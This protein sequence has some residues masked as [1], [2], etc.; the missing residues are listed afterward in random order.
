VLST[1]S[2]RASDPVPLAADRSAHR[3]FE[4]VATGA[5][6]MLVLAVAWPVMA[7][8]GVYPWA[9]AV[10]ATLTLVF[11][12]LAVTAGGWR[13]DTRL[14]LATL[15]VLVAVGLQLIPL[16][17]DMLASISPATVAF[18]DSYNLGYALSGQ[19][20]K[21]PAHPLSID[22]A[23]TWRFVLFFLIA[24]ALFAGVRSLG[25]VRS[26]RFLVTT[27]TILGAT[28]ALIGLIQAG[29]GS[30]RMYGVLAPQTTAAVFGPFV[31]R[32]HFAALMLMAL[33]VAMT[34]CAASI[35]AMRRQAG[36]SARLVGL[37][38]TPAAS[39]GLL[40]AFAALV[41]SIALLMTRSRSGIAG[42]AIV[43][44]AVVAVIV[45][46]RRTRRE[47]VVVSLLTGALGFAVTTWIGWESLVARFDELPSTG[48]SGR[49][50]AWS[51]GVRIARAFWPIGSG[52]NTYASATLAYHD[53]AVFLYFRTPHN[54]YL[55]ALTDGGLLVGIPLAVLVGLLAMRIAQAV[56]S[57]SQQ[58]SFDA[59]TR[60]GAAAGLLAVALQEIVDF[61]LQTPANTVLFA[62]LSAYILSEPARTSANAPSRRSVKL[63][64]E[65]VTEAVS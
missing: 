51:E 59:W 1:L 43:L 56:R 9:Y 7:F 11:V 47:V 4:N 22:P 44:A 6:G 46:R 28:V 16:P 45:V 13:M 37:I 30:N 14:V 54:D 12:V 38:G 34:Q 25:A 18:L 55:Q 52:L 36:P 23:A 2:P 61:S 10:L 35:R 19:M 5:A 15:A 42:F 65:R 64:A 50:D 33:P 21:R 53:P 63:P 58:S 57:T 62:V 8:G 48:M 41:M 39:Q 31:N 32:N 40:T 29:L 3:A 17:G 27:I 24:C 60:G 26:L 20:G 49:V